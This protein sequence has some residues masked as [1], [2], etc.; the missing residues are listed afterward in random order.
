MD[1]KK[2]QEMQILEQ[3]LQQIFMQKQSFEMELQETEAGLA[4]L[5]SSKADEAFKI[6]G[7]LM[8]K[9]DKEKMKEEL[10]GKEK[11]LKMRLESIAKQ[12]GAFMEKAEELRKEVVK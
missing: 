2:M 11:I 1:E 9:T 7:Q 4:E 6:I 3:N 12:E 8:I 5:N 10:V